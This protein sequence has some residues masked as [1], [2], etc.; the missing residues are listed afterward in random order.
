[1][2]TGCEKWYIAVLIGGNKFIWKE[3]PRNAADIEALKKA[4]VSWRKW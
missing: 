4:A 2:V 3:V 1:M